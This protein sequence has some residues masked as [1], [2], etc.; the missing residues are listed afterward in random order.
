VA[1]TAESGGRFGRALGRLDPEAFAAF[2]AAVHEADP[3]VDAVEVEGGCLVVRGRTERR[4]RLVADR[5]RLRGPGTVGPANGAVD[6][7][8]TQVA[9]AGR[10]TAVGHDARLVGPAALRDRVCYGLPRADAE[11]LLDEHLGVDRAAAL[12][13]DRRRPP[14][15]LGLA[16]VL[17]LGLVAGVLGTAVAGPSAGPVTPAADGDTATATERVRAATLPP[18]LASGGVTDA[19]ALA[20]AHEAAT[21]GRRYAVAV[22]ARN[23]P[24][25]SGPGE[26]EN[27]EANGVVAGPRRYRGSVGG[28]RVTEDERWWRLSRLYADGDRLYERRYGAYAPVHDVRPAPA[29]PPM[30]R[31]P[32]DLRRYLSV[33]SSPG[34]NVTAAEVEGEWGHR[35]SVGRA[36]PGVAAESYLAVARLTERGRVTSLD[37]SYDRPDGERVSLELRYER[38]T[39]AVRPPEWLGEARRAADGASGTRAADATSETD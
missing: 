33:R 13:P 19:A 20:R 38:T 7:V 8:V 21:E 6:A 28:V 12:A 34:G 25:L 36:P 17:A 10:R 37:V 39:E 26:W 11:R 16:V 23:V 14:V 24:A 3:D 27:L 31:G 35:V 1:P 15:A 9:G 29:R 18:G 4:L 22:E 30:D 2:V 32:R 5:G